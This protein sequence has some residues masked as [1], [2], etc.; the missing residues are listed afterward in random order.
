MSSAPVVSIVDDD[1]SVRV[2]TGNLVRSFGYVVHTFASAEAFLDSTQL[3]QTACVIADVRMFTMSGLEMQ[4]RLRARGSAMPFI[5]ITA[6]PDA[7]VRARAFAAGASGFL[8]KPF[9]E[10]ALRHCIEGALRD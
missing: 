6:V 8:T 5:F 10:N 2:A 7:K 4:D 1:A 3:E 9:D